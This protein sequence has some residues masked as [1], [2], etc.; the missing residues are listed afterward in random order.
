M[1]T[2]TLSAAELLELTGR[3]R[4]SAQRVALQRLGLRYGV[5]PDGT[6]VLLRKHVEQVLGVD[7]AGAATIAVREPQVRD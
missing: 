1:T 3:Q 2:L 5:R 4:P 7:T 6:L